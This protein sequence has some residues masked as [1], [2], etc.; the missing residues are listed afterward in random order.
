[1]IVILLNFSFA[2]C[3]SFPNS[4]EIVPVLTNEETGTTELEMSQYVSIGTEGDHHKQGGDSEN[5]E[6]SYKSD[7]ISFTNMH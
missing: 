3:A 2:M 1:M 6:A 5:I 4:N 7:Y